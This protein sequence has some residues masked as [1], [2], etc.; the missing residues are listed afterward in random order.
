MCEPSM[1]AQGKERDQSPVR[2]LKPLE[3]VSLTAK[4]WGNPKLSVTMVGAGNEWFPE[5]TWSPPSTPFNLPMQ[6]PLSLHS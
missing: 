6:Q 4:I 2:A 1:K 5:Q 3:S